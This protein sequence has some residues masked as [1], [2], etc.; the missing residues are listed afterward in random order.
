MNV[1]I[2]YRNGDVAYGTAELQRRLLSPLCGLVQ[3]VSFCVRNHLEPRAIAAGAE[4][5]GV[6]LLLN[7]PRPKPGFYHIGGGGFF[8]EE[9]SIRALAESIERYSQFV[10]WVSGRHKIVMATYHELQGTGE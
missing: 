1:A 5:T 7:Q 10:S 3:G 2:A 6:H 4:L 9:S 8:L